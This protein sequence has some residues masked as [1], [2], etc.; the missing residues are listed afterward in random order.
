MKEINLLARTTTVTSTTTMPTRKN[1]FLTLQA[2]IRRESENRVMRE[3]GKN[4]DNGN[5]KIVFPKN[6]ERKEE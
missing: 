1:A 3:K 4:K 2:D 5:N 6:Y